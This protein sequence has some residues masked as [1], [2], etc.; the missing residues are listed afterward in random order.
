MDLINEFWIITFDGIPLFSYSPRGKLNSQL[1]GGFFSAIQ[2]FSSEMGD[3]K[4]KYINSLNLGD[5]NFHFLINKPREL[6]FI[7]KSSKRL[8]EKLIGSHLKELERMFIQ[9]FDS[10]IT[11]FKGETS[12][13]NKFTPK[14]KD[15]FDNKLTKLK[16]LW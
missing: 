8:K 10:E 9:R 16:S 5:S 6:F 14:F 1:I 2:H 11:D 7:A 13:F 12:Q 15:Y 4:N 3:S